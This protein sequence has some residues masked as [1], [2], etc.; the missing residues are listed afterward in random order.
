MADLSQAMGVHPS[1]IYAATVEFLG[2]EQHTSWP[3]T[4][5]NMHAATS[6]D[7]SDSRAA[8]RKVASFIL[9][10]LLKAEPIGE[11]CAGEP[12]IPIDCDL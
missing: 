3:F 4:R 8:F 6:E 5:A 9:I 2:P 11:P 1:S 10:L 7:V 12:P